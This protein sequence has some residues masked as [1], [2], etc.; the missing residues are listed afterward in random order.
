M[1]RARVAWLVAALASGC[2]EAPPSAEV[3]GGDG[4][5]GPLQFPPADASVRVA[6]AIAA[7]VDSDGRDDLLLL[8]DDV[9][10]DWAG[11]Y[12]LW[13]GDGG[14][15]A[16]QE[17]KLGFR[18]ASISFGRQVKPAGPALV[19]GAQNG[20]VSVVDYKP[21]EKD[22]AVEELALAPPLTEPVTIVDTGVA[23]EEDPTASLI[24]YD[25]S[26]LWASVPI[27]DQEE[28]GLVATL[29]GHVL[30]AAAW[31]LRTE[32]PIVFVGARTDIGVAW[33]GGEF[34]T[35]TGVAAPPAI[36]AAFGHLVTGMC[37]THLVVGDDDKLSIG[38]IACDGSDG[39][40]A[41]L[42]GSDLKQV[43]AMAA[44]DIAGG[45]K[46]DVALLGLDSGGA[47]YG[48]VLIDITYDEGTPMF[49]ADQTSGGLPLD[50]LIPEDAFLVI[51]DTEADGSALAF[52][53]AKSGRLFCGEV[54][55]MTIAPCGP[56]WDIVMAQ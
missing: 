10:D 52:A 35:G 24:A 21:E 15:R 56:G 47:L 49:A 40:I 16:L 26:T 20:D 9:E 7:D 53:I 19:V 46:H 37:G 14:W 45:A 32:D 12:I 33:F 17:V 25:G 50:G 3:P 51:A 54:I 44:G 34:G 36:A 30:A 42:V 27:T 55:D 2:L 39:F 43:T 48:E 6:A 1:G 8:D 11:I 5:G 38:W 13:A 22:F 31:P 41:P 4:P 29:G 23:L 28:M 18:P